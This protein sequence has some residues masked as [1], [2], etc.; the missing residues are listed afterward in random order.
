MK[1]ILKLISG[2]ALL[3][4]I[5]MGCEHP[6]RMETKVHEDGSLDKVIEMDKVDSVVSVSNVFGINE[7]KGWKVSV[8][9]SDSD[10]TT[11]KDEFN[12]RFE[13]S[14]PSAEAANLDL[15][16]E[17]DTLFQVKTKFDKS[18]R[19][20]YTYIRYSETFKRIDRLKKVKGEDYFNQE[21]QSFINRLSGEG[22]VISK[23]DSFY[24]QN[25]NDK[26]FKS[27]A[28]MG[29]FLEQYDILSEVIKRNADKKWLDTLAKNVE[30]IYSRLED[31]EGDPL[32]AT[33]IADSLHIPLPKEKAAKDFESLAEDLNSRIQ[34]MS[35]ARDGRYLN[36]FEMPWTVVSSNADSVGGN[37]LYWKPLVTKF[38]IQEYEM[39]AEA[40]K[41]NIWAVLV[42][43]GI[44]GATLFLF[45]RKKPV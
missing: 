42:S 16:S 31:L 4:G 26:I 33:K 45:L 44:I 19:W 40:R 17:S 24:L 14:F 15:G 43:V 2:L 20:F 5:L 30:F 27:Y 13:K 18:F 7:S 3:S 22:T 25:L 39:F 11:S 10:S 36:S 1:T 28:R 29:M 38:A 6:I 35:F 21:D 8:R 9:R 23:A 41:L 12:I 32:F 37:K 34:F